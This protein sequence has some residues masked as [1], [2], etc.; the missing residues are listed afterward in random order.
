MQAAMYSSANML[1]TTTAL[2]CHLQ[3]VIYAGWP[4]NEDTGDIDWSEISSKE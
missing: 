2:T 3:N 1:T 4:R